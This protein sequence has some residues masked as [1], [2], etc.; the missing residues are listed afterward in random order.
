LFY[1]FASTL[2]GLTTNSLSYHLYH[3]ST[4]TGRTIIWY[5]VGNE[6]SR[7]PLF[8]W[9]Y[10]SFW[11]IGPDSPNILEGWDFI[12]GMPNAH[13]GYYDTR[14]ELGYLGFGLLLAFIFSTLHGVRR[15]A[16]RDSSRAHVVLSICLLVIFHNF[17]ESIW[18]RSYDVQWVM[19]LLMGAEIA[20]YQR[21][22]PTRRVFTMAKWTPSRIKHRSTH[23]PIPPSSRVS[24][25]TRPRNQPGTADACPTKAP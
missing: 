25:R 18:L 23:T 5:F 9:G 21:S 7:R 10:K 6:I 11:L 2:T 8:G 12:K 1:I 14:L 24:F 17:L 19:F 13:S 20:R 4:F 16:D 15:M 3:D 22:T